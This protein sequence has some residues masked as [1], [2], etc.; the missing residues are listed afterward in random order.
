MKEMGKGEIGVVRHVNGYAAIIELR[1]GT[2]LL[3]SMVELNIL[4][5]S[6]VRNEM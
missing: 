6:K 3:D 2:V 5:I 1:T 4:L